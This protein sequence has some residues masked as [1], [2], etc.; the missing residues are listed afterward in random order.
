MRVVPRLAP[1]A[2][3][4][5]PCV[6]RSCPRRL[7]CR[8]P[9]CYAHAGSVRCGRD[10]GSGIVCGLGDGRNRDASVGVGRASDAHRG[11]LSVRGFA[12]RGRA[13]S[14]HSEHGCDAIERRLEAVKLTAEVVEDWRA[15]LDESEN[16]VCARSEEHT[17]ELQSLMRISYAVFCLKK[18][19]T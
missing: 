6:C 4:N 3:G 18:K 8:S 14:A 12:G 5:V 11:G 1:S 16:Y 17:S 10:G 15:A 9:Y 19:N 13:V 2:A 7:G